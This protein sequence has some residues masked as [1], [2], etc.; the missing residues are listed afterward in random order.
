MEGIAIDLFKCPTPTNLLRSTDTSQKKMAG[1]VTSRGPIDHQLGGMDSL[2][3][4][5][6]PDILVALGVR[7]GVNLAS[8]VCHRFRSAVK[9]DLV[10]A[11]WLIQEFPEQQFLLSSRLSARDNLIRLWTTCCN[12]VH[13]RQLLYR[14]LWTKGDWEYSCDMKFY[15]KAEE[16]SVEVGEPGEPTII[17]LAGEILWTLR[18]CP[19]HGFGSYLTERIGA[20]TGRGTEILEGSMTM[21]NGRIKDGLLVVKGVS[22]ADSTL[23]GVSNECQWLVVDGGCSLVSASKEGDTGQAAC[24]APEEQV[25]GSAN[26]DANE[27]IEEYLEY[28]QKCHKDYIKGSL[29][30]RI[31]ESE[32]DAE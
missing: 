30:E 5:H 27:S 26:L 23:I 12:A 11:C 18:S 31:R 1:Q 20:E 13:G 15:P 14:G 7:C 10:W 8:L 16:Q 29:R 9:D 4:H 6:L 21:I 22:V 17:A 28:I 24:I 25:E 19:S 32:A 2:D 3:S